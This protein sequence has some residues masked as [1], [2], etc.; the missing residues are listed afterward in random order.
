MQSIACTYLGVRMLWCLAIGFVP[1][2]AVAVGDCNAFAGGGGGGAAA[3]LA[4][5]SCCRPGGFGARFG[6][7]LSFSCDSDRSRESGGGGGGCVESAAA[8]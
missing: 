4:A 5:I 7:E 8:L 1:F 6:F 3:A 2:V